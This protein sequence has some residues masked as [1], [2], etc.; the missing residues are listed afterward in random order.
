MEVYVYAL[1]FG[2]VERAPRL[3]HL[4]RAH[5]HVNVAERSEALFRVE[6]CR[7]PALQ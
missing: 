4:R 6:A 7:G 2:H 3:V 5:V 1:G